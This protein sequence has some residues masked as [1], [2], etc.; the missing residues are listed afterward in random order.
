MTHYSTKALTWQDVKKEIVACDNWL[1]ELSNEDLLWTQD[2]DEKNTIAWEMVSYT[3]N[4]D[5][6]SNLFSM[7]KEHLIENEVFRYNRIL[8]FIQTSASF[9]QTEERMKEITKQFENLL[10]MGYNVI[11]W[12][13]SQSGYD[14]TKTICAV[15]YNGPLTPNNNRAL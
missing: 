2:W 13:I 9:V 11:L 14:L 4:D 12:G 6:N 3:Q 15:N 7:I 8:L 1:I 10:D 5:M